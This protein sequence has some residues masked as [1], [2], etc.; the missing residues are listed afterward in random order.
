MLLTVTRTMMMQLAAAW[1]RLPAAQSCLPAF[2][3]KNGNVVNVRVEAA[4]ERVQ[5]LTCRSV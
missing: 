5:R 1:R 3:L 4:R 2:S